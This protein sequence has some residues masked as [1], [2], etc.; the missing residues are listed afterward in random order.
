MNLCSDQSK[1]RQELSCKSQARFFKIEPCGELIAPSLHIQ[2]FKSLEPLPGLPSEVYYVY[3]C[4]DLEERKKE[5]YITNDGFL[6]HYIR[7]ASPFTFNLGHGI[8]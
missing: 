8:D 5:I 3:E 6:S 1:D 4:F 7:E 2:S